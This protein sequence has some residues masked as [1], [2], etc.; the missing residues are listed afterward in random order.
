MNIVAERWFNAQFHATPAENCDV[1]QRQIL[2]QLFIESEWSSELSCIPRS[3][4]KSVVICHKGLEQSPHFMPRCYF[5]FR[6][7]PNWISLV[8]FKHFDCES[9][10]N[11]SVA[12]GRPTIVISVRMAIGRSQKSTLSR[13]E[14]QLEKSLYFI[15]LRSLSP[16]WQHPN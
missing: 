4:T 6:Q 7:S 3:A 13:H 8:K 11:V 12:E 2:I 16:G 5:V 14:L 1:V 9:S 10:A 15:C